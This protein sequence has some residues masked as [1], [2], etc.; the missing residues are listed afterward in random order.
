MLT[1]GYITNA[2]IQLQTNCMNYIL[3]G[4]RRQLLSSEFNSTFQ[5]A[6]PDHFYK[7]AQ[8]QHEE[9]FWVSIN[10]LRVEIV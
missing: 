6:G 1:N 3:F 5:I 8:Q 10:D 9:Y 2:I 4:P 7:L